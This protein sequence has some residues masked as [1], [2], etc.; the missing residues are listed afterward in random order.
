MRQYAKTRMVVG[1]RPTE[2][3]YFFSIYLILPATL[4]PG[5]YSAS[6]RNKYQKQKNY[7]SGENIVAGEYG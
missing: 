3:N 6:N 2:V 7:I 5:V 4:R 1:S